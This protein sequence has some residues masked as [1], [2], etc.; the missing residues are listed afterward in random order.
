VDKKVK[1]AR[2]N[3]FVYFGK[4]FITQLGFSN[5]KH[6][7][8]IHYNLSRLNNNIISTVD[9]TYTLS[10]IC[11]WAVIIFLQTIYKQQHA[12]NTFCHLTNLLYN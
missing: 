12:R 8:H 7:L 2:L 9:H 11:V 10:N 5:L 1:I 6:W 4:Q 3:Y